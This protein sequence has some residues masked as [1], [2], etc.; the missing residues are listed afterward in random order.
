MNGNQPLKINQY[1][2]NKMNKNVCLKKL[3]KKT[4]QALL[5]KVQILVATN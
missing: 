1:Y 4:Y 2:R 5:L 3:E